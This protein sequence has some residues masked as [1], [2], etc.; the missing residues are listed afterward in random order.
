[1]QCLTLILCRRRGLSPRIVIQ[2]PMAS[3]DAHQEKKFIV[4][5]SR[6]FELFKRCHECGSSDVA[7]TERIIGTFVSISQECRSC[8]NGTRTWDSQPWYGNIPAGNLLLSAATLFAGGSC[9]KMLRILNIMRVATISES[10]FYRHQSSILQPAIERWWKHHQKAIIAQFKEA[11]QPLTLGGDGRADSPGHS[12]KF[13]A[14][15][16]IELSINKIIDINLVQVK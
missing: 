3:E 6:L 15:S 8:N 16:V 14:Y 11:G 10:S 2:Q 13:G 4:F 12:A 1:M 5:S 9:A 7:V